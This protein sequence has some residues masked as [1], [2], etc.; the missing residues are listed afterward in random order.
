MLEE[1]PA[2]ITVHL[3]QFEKYAPFCMPGAE[4]TN[5]F[6][7]TWLRRGGRTIVAAPFGRRGVVCVHHGG[8]CALVVCAVGVVSLRFSC[9]VCYQKNGRGCLASSTLGMGWGGDPGEGGGRLPPL[10]NGR[11][12]KRVLSSSVS[13]FPCCVLVPHHTID[14][15]VNYIGVMCSVIVSTSMY[16]RIT[17]SSGAPCSLRI[18]SHSS[19]S[20]TIAC[21]NGVWLYSSTDHLRLRSTLSSLSS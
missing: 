15:A 10:H 16:V 5:A 9:A 7:V 13:S 6:V 12:E 17:H 3:V 11:S 1:D 21:C 18:F 20:R 8:R 19:C 2:K 4:G 14:C